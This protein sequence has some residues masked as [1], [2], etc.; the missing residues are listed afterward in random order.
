MSEHRPYIVSCTKI[1]QFANKT[2]NIKL[3]NI[4]IYYLKGKKIYH[5]EE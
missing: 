2:Q 3:L 5:F 4:A 1:N